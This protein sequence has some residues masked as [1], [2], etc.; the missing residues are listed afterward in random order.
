MFQ[1]AK[2]SLGE[3]LI[4][5]DEE[6]CLF[7]PFQ[8]PPLCVTLDRYPVQRTGALIKAAIAGHTVV[9]PL[10]STASRAE[11]NFRWK[12]HVKMLR[13]VDASFFNRTHCNTGHSPVVLRCKG[14]V[15]KIQ[16]LESGDI[17]LISSRVNDLFWSL[18]RSAHCYF[19]V[20]PP[21]F[22]FLFCS[23][24]EIFKDNQV[25]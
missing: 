22:F 10:W 24:T 17:S 9:V 5:A 14:L 16:G 18:E 13:L 4:G 6:Q 3:A 2:L 21:I 15:C 25:F 7:K 20:C 12:E 8:Q 1:G 23:Y 11:Y 19:P